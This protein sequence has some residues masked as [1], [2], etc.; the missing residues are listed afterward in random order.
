MRPTRGSAARL[1]RGLARFGRPWTKGDVI[2]LGILLAT[3]AGVVALIVVS[4]GDSTKRGPRVSL[5]SVAYRLGVR[6]ETVKVVG[7]AAG[8]D[9]GDLI[10]AIA[11]PQ[12][13]AASWWSAAAVP[14][15]PDG[16]WAASIVI[17]PPTT[18]ELSVQAVDL[19]SQALGE[20]SGAPTAPPPT[21][22]HVQTTESPKAG[23]KLQESAEQ[24][25]SKEEAPRSGAEGPTAPG[26]SSPETRASPEAPSSL[27]ERGPN[28]MGIRAT[29]AT[30]TAK[31]TQ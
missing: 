2:A 5:R 30:I 21:T 11:R 28:A 13:T 27:A 25:S 12:G 14:A 8:L 24:E 4:S 19:E 7:F 29:S 26:G 16:Q 20:Q 9:A 22:G 1:A 23:R 15:H 6:P 18:K 3:V 31:P 17:E 10:Y